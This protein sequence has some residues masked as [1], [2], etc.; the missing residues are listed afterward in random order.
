MRPYYKFG[1]KWGLTQLSTGQPFFV[2]TNT[3]DVASWIVMGG[4]WE[5]FVDDLLC[6]LARPG[7]TFFD[8]GANLG[9]YTVK[10]GG[11]VGPQGHILSF[12]PNPQMFEMLRENVAINGYGA[13]AQIFNLALGA[14]PGELTLAFDPAHPGGA[15]LLLSGEETPADMSSARVQIATLDSLVGADCIA[16]LIKIDVE[17]FEPL[18]FQG[19]Q[20]LLARSPDAAIVSEV[21]VSQWERFGDPAELIT[22]L[23]DGRRMF[24]I[25]YDSHLEELDAQ[26]LGA[27]LSRDF[28]SY[29]LLLPRTPGR[30]AQLDAYLKRFEAPEPLPAQSEAPAPEPEPVSAPAPAPRPRSLLHRALGRLIRL[31]P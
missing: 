5:H 23:A 21:S 18:V 26:A 17:G 19:M 13:R 20:A 8:I 28:V 12:E 29:V 9:Y 15:S 24:R 14:E 10:I 2:D 25:F 3:R 22:R 16:D 11:L 7:D 31:I 4:A 30:T 27:S 1:G 6:A